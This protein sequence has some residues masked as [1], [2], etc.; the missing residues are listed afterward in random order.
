MGSNSVSSEEAMDLCAELS[1]NSTIPV[2]YE[3]GTVPSA[4]DSAG[5]YYKVEE[6]TDV[7]GCLRRCCES[8]ECHGAFYFGAKGDCYR[9]VCEFRSILFLCQ[10]SVF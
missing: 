5:T 1:K 10:F 9:I 3:N 8:S 2:V 7:A 4:G 6:A